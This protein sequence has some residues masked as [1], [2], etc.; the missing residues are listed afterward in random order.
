M[1]HE[2][3]H[4]IK[5]VPMQAR[6]KIR[7]RLVNINR[8][9]RESDVICKNELRVNRH[10]F[11]VLCEMLHHH[12]LKKPTSIPEDCED[13]RWKYFKRCLGALDG[14]FIS[15]HVSHIDRSRYR[16]RKGALAMNVL[17]V[18]TPNMEF[19]YV[20]PGWE[21]SAH[22]GR[23][24]RDA[25]SRPNGLKVPKGYYYLVDAGYTNCEGFLAPYRGHNY[26]LK[27]WGDKVPENPEEYFNMK[28]AKARNV[29]EKCFGLLKGRWAILRSPSF[30]PIITQGWIV[31]VMNDSSQ[32]AGR[33][34]NKRKWSSL[35]EE[36]LL[37]FILELKLDP[38]WK[39]EGG[40]KN[41]F[42]QCLAEKMKNKFPE[43][44][45][46]ASQ[47]ESKIK[48]LKEKYTII[49]DMLKSSGFQW[50]DK[51]KMVQCE[52]QCFDEFCV[53]IYDADRADGS[54]SEDM[55]DNIN[56]MNNE[57]IDLENDLEDSDVTELQTQPPQKRKKKGKSPL[58]SNDKLVIAI[59]TIKDHMCTIADT[60]KEAQKHEK[61]VVEQKKNLLSEVAMIEGVSQVDAIDATSYL[62]R[63]SSELDAFYSCP[64]DEWKK[65]YVERLIV[66]L[67]GGA[68]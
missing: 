2:Q 41:G 62:S 67:R 33:G 57:C 44:G 56:N 60:W 51:N 6:D 61:K 14:T 38:R 65:L 31:S 20:L 24:L 17:G 30:F 55:N 68:T 47:V 9:I 39:C 1:I 49:S 5:E 16:T 52:R 12:L 36:T 46:K 22:D 11:G 26:H 50:D 18:C 64:N 25:I 66:R 28:H 35:E 54:R 13:S 34:K 3:V 10:T 23:I 4:Q 40:F 15:V 32:A 53:I 7:H 58:V 48:F 63:N 8:L 37:D 21:R 19:I 45:L 42:H 43:C 27:D 59:D 29:I